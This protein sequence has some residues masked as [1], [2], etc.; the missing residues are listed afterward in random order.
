MKSV[1][2]KDCCSHC[3]SV[4]SEV[5]M[6]CEPDQTGSEAVSVGFELASWDCEHVPTTVIE[7]EGEANHHYFFGFPIAQVKKVRNNCTSTEEISKSF[8]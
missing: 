8:H 4:L 5:E 2:A 6:R 3:C 7:S 1:E